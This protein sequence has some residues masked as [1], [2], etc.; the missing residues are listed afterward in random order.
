MRC[1]KTVSIM[2]AQHNLAKLVRE[3]EAGRGLLITRRKKVVAQLTAPGREG[4]ATFPDF[5][6]RAKA[7]W[8]KGWRGA[9]S[10]ELLREG[11]G[12]R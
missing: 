5:K 4:A 12:D 11:R 6:A 8:G 3:V 7:T 9:G 10:D 2:D 1:M